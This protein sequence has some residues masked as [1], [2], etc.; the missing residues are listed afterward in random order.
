MK[1][2]FVMKDFFGKKVRIKLIQ[3]KLPNG[4]QY[5]IRPFQLQL[6]EQDLKYMEKCSQ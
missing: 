4:K 5:W 3:I 1:P 6:I 2:K